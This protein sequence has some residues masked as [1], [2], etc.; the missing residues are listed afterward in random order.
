MFFL[1][2]AQETLECM[3]P[4]LAERLNRQTFEV[5]ESRGNPGIGDFKQCGGPGLMIPTRYAGKG[6]SSLEACQ[7]QLAI[8]AISPSLAVA[9]MMHHFSAATLVEIAANQGGKISV[10]L[11]MVARENLLM[12]SGFAE[13]GSGANILHP[14]T[15]LIRKGGRYCV[16]GSKKP[17]S[18][19]HSMDLLT[20]S[21]LVPGDVP[22]TNAWP[23]PSCLPARQAWSDARSGTH[24]FWPAPKATKWS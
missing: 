11:E 7:V 8:G 6:A 14:F 15:R 22:V 19:A 5:L 24:P 17:C 13:G 4:G 18:L 1:Q 2:R 20:L 9:T 12:A 23:W 3:I 21:V 16:S 10:V